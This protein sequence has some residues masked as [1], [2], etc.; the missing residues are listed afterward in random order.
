MN[1]N[2]NRWLNENVVWIIIGLISVFLFFAFL[3]PI[4]MKLDLTVQAKFI[5]RI[6]NAFCHQLAFRG[7]FL[8]GEQVFYPRRISGVNVEIYYED[9]TQSNLD[10]NYARD[11][12][13][14]R[15][16]GYKIALCQRDI[17]IYG[18]F[19]ITGIIFQVLKNKPKPIPWY[20]WVVVGLI[21]LGIDG[22]TQFGGL[23]INLFSF[24]PVRESTPLLRTL[25][26]SLFG[27]LTGL[28]I[29]PTLVEIGQIKSNEAE[30]SE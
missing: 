29:F 19:L 24:L 13:G 18:T 9:I 2:L 27:I 23:G 25:T 21:P 22:V 7:Y 30:N 20:I 26:G 8:F 14:N 16:I 3:A 15:L 11:F 17:A 6:Y 1:R 5:Y 12:L 4:L 28:F 10:L